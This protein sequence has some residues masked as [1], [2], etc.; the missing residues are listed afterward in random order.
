MQEHTKAI[1][2][3]QRETEDAR[4]GL[5]RDIKDSMARLVSIFDPTSRTRRSSPPQPTGRDQE[6]FT[7]SAQRERPLILP[8]L[9]QTQQ[10]DRTALNPDSAKFASESV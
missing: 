4:D 6:P 5:I 2:A 3:S 8:A 1:I 10:G 9:L 7:P